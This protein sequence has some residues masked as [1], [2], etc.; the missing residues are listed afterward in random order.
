MFIASE[1][2]WLMISAV[3]FNFSIKGTRSFWNTQQ[4][5]TGSLYPYARNRHCK[6]YY[7]LLYSLAANLHYYRH[8]CIL[9]PIPINAEV[10]SRGPITRLLRIWINCDR[11][12]NIHIMACTYFKLHNTLV[13]ICEY[14]IIITQCHN[15]IIIERVI[16]IVCTYKYKKINNLKKY[17]DYMIYLI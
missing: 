1:N 5:L 15:M 8:Y 12:Y 10:K 4:L 16:R 3:L 6:Y 9:R 17:C 11:N 7:F 14:I 2:S 13:N